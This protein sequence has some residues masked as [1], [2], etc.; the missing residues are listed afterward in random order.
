MRNTFDRRK[1]LKNDSHFEKMDILKF[2][3]LMTI[4]YDQRDEDMLH[5]VEKQMYV[6]VLD[7]NIHHKATG[8]CKAADIIFIR[9]S[10][11]TTIT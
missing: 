7:R 2:Q 11:S 5:E 3:W 6:T 8:P 9:A 4:T 1:R 10:S